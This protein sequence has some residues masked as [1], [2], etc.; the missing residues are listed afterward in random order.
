MSNIDLFKQR[1]KELRGKYNM[2]QQDL[3]NQLGIVRTAIANY[4]TGRTNPDS[5]TLSLIA[6]IFDTSTDYLL[7][8]TDIKEPIQ[9][10]VSEKTQKYSSSKESIDI[11]DLSPESQE[12]LKKYI[13]LLRLKDMQKRNIEDNDELATLD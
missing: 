10:I 6:N 2:T 5:E 1:L 13:E 9:N 12:D 11:A 3:A 7:G 8:R 4:E